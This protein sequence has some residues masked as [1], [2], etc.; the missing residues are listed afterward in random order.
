MGYIRIK[1]TIGDNY[2]VE[3]EFGD[4]VSSE[5]VFTP[6]RYKSKSLF[7]V[8]EYSPGNSK[9]IRTGD[10]V[11][12]KP[13]SGQD[14][15]ERFS[16]V[17]YDDIIGIDDGEFPLKM[18]RDHILVSAIKP[19]RASKNIFL[20]ERGSSQTELTG[21]NDCR[22]GVVVSVGSGYATDNG[23]IPLGVSAGEYI[24][25]H[26]DITSGISIVIDGEE[27]RVLRERDIILSW[28]KE[29]NE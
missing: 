3:K 9:E 2:V 25:F 27:Y 5:I 6:E 14:I 18:I 17:H 22:L 8:V 19:I 23:V 13:D 12:L 1:D 24:A 15:D 11:F 28:S 29:E 4:R 16:I 20:P 7:A 26:G 21:I 10:R